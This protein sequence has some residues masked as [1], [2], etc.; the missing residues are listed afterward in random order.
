MACE[1]IFAVQGRNHQYPSLS[2]LGNYEFDYES[3]M[4]EDS[5]IC[6]S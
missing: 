3:F 4:H 5:D 2:L 1:L 6:N